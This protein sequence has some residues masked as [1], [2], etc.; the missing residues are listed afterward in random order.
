MWPRYYLINSTRKQVTHIHEE[1][2][3]N[4]NPITE[5]RATITNPKELTILALKYSAYDG[6]DHYARKKS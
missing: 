1:E 6:L 5:Y 3:L 4:S 2:S